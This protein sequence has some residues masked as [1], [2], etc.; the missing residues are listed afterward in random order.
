MLAFHN[1]HISSKLLRSRMLCKFFFE[2]EIAIAITQI[3]MNGEKMMIS[4]YVNG[5]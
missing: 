5:F 4:F 2:M 1:E 3:E